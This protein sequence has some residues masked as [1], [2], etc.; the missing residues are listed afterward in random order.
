MK[1]TLLRY[2]VFPLTL[3][4]A[5]G[6]ASA[7][8]VFV[9]AESLIDH[10]GWKLDTQF[11][12]EMGSPYL[13]AHGLGRPV[14]N[15]R[16]RASFPGTGTYRVFVRTKDWTARWGAEQSPGQFQLKVGGTLL[17][18]KFGTVGKK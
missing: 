4:G 13:L 2:L 7:A 17:A 15:A 12:D 6:S 8:E 5:G 10:G 3:F 1:R 9:E 18:P 11:I 14:A 16:G